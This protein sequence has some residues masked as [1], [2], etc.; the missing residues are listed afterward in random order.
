MRFGVVMFFLNPVPSLLPWKPTSC[1]PT[2]GTKAMIHELA[3]SIHIFQVIAKKNALLCGNTMF[4]LDNTK[5]ALPVNNTSVKGDYRFF[6][7][8]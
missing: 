4:P 6:Q 2:S 1:V 3:F 7:Y 8:F 5:I